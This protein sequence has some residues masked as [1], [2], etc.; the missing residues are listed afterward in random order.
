MADLSLQGTLTRR[1]AAVLGALL[2]LTTLAVY[3]LGGLYIDLAYDRALYDDVATLGAQ[4]EIRDERVRF[5]LPGAARALLLADDDRV[6]YRV[7][8]LKMGTV[9]DGNGDLGAW[10]PDTAVEGQPYYR[11][12]RAGGDHFRIAYARRNLDPSEHPV[13]IEVGETLG[14]RERA[15][16]EILLGVIGLMLLLSA[17][18]VVALRQGVRDAL[19]PLARLEAQAARRSGEDLAPLDPML[20]PREA[21]ALIEAINRMMQRVSTMVEAQRRFVSNASHQLRTPIAGVRLQAQIAL[22]SAAPPAVVESLR[23]I[24]T[25][26]TRA[27][28][29]IEQLLVLSA[30]DA[31]DFDSSRRPVDL[32]R[33]AQSVIEGA[34]PQALRG[35][36]VLDYDGPDEGPVVQGNPTLLTEMVLNLVDNALRYNAPGGR[37][38]VCV[39]SEAGEVYIG[40]VDDGP[41]LPAGREALFARFQRGDN[42]QGEG[43]GLG[44]AIVKEIADR[45]GA[46]IEVDSGPDRGTR[47]VALFASS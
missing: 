1:L 31:D 12:T 45:H 37:A 43:A 14:K 20:A 18:C 38:T 2:V 42:A 26:A 27:A 47:I 36:Q 40:V 15:R 8:D 23:E 46:R 22:K 33:L 30:A 28:H 39:G 4:V 7:I 16:H 34:M 24:Q 17:L 11:D 29:L 41:G 32:A 25:S 35:D 3:G 5:S 13:L 19:A 10:D 6:I 9:V 21:R 44:L